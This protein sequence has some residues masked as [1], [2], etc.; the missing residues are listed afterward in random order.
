VL[1][2]TVP[3]TLD[4]AGM[5]MTLK[6]GDVIE[7][8]QLANMFTRLANSVEGPLNRFAKTA[9]NI[10]KLAAT[11]TTLGERLNEMVEPRTPA[12]VD[13][14]KPANLRSSIMRIDKAMADADAWLT[15]KQL[16]EDAKALI[17][18]ANGVLDQAADLAKA[19]TGTADKTDKAITD[20]SAKAATVLDQGAATLANANTALNKVDKAAGEL[21]AVLE[22]VNQGKEHWDNSP[23]T[24]TSTTPSAMLRSAWTG[25]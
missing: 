18:K 7:T 21:A 1:E 19:W 6:D 13:A 4:E 16:R 2:L 8:G 5:R 15:D 17:A 12:E 22:G 20:V 3:P 10:D 14:G 23:R 9:D 24:P 25:R 11:Y